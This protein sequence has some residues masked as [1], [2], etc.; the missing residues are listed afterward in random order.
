MATI[1]IATAAVARM[2]IELCGFMLREASAREVARP[3]TSPDLAFNLNQPRPTVDSTT[4]RGI[5]A[6]RDGRRYL[7]SRMTSSMPTGTPGEVLYS[8]QTQERKKRPL[9]MVPAS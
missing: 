7:L 1:T 5:N 8:T 2:R 6:S 3:T 9:L 4:G